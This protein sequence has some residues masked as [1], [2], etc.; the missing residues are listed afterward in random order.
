MSNCVIIVETKWRTFTAGRP[1][2]ARTGYLTGDFRKLRPRSAF[3][4]M[5]NVSYSPRSWLLH[6]D[7]FSATESNVHRNP[8]I[9]IRLKYILFTTA[10]RQLAHFN[11]APSGGLNHSHPAISLLNK[12]TPSG[13]VPS[14]IYTSNWYMN[15]MATKRFRFLAFHT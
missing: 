5:A 14:D 15:T 4:S 3:D 13:S 9:Y 2:Y 1:P 11:N 8:S 12:E 10:I 7:S 6:Q